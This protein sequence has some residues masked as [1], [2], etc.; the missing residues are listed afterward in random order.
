VWD[1]SHLLMAGPKTTI[2]G[3]AFNGSMRSLDPATGGVLWERGLGG[4]ILGTPSVSAGGVIAAATYDSTTGVTNGTYLLDARD[5][6]QLNFLSFANS[7]QFAQPVFVGN[8]LLMA[9]QF[10]GLNVYAVSTATDTTP[11][12]APATLTHHPADRAS[13]PHSHGL[14]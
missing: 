6:R 14:Q 10:G 4:L 8:D 9:S 11:P 13:H 1:G 3:T 5:G 12:T 7:K 2:A